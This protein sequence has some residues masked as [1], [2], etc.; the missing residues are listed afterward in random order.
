MADPASPHEGCTGMPPDS[1]KATPSDHRTMR[2]RLP[3]GGL[4]GSAVWLLCQ[5]RWPYP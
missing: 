4:A 3:Y 1:G 2:P 5:A